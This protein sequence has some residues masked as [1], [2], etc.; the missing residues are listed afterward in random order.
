MGIYQ[1]PSVNSR[2]LFH[3]KV[4][5]AGIVAFKGK[6]LISKEVDNVQSASTPSAGILYCEGYKIGA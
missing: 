6:D 5:K 3:T 2:R 4:H 1:R